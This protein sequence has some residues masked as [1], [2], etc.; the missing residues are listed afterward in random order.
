MNDL[1]VGDVVRLKSGGIKMTVYYV[2][3]ETIAV[4]YYNES[5]N[6]IEKVQQMEPLAF[7]LAS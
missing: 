2:G 1:K 5:T 3:T 4:M 7:E 6:S